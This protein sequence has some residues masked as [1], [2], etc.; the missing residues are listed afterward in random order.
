MLL[1]AKHHPADMNDVA[2]AQFL[3]QRSV[4]DKGKLLSI[5]M[6][7]PPHLVH[8]ENGGGCGRMPHAALASYIYTGGS[9]KL[10]ASMQPT[11]CSGVAAST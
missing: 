6:R 8:A 7:A 4:A 9:G 5:A 11:A 2:C 10:A 1:A 3:A